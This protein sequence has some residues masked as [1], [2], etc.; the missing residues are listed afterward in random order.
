M[1]RYVHKMQNILFVSGDFTVTDTPNWIHVNSVS[2][3]TKESR[4]ISSLPLELNWHT[5]R[6]SVV[7]IVTCTPLTTGRT[8]KKEV[9]VLV[10]Q[11]AAASLSR[12]TFTLSHW[13]SS[14]RSVHR[15]LV[16]TQQ[17]GGGTC[18]SGVSFLWY[19]F[20]TWA[21]SFVFPVLFCSLFHSLY[22]CLTSIPLSSAPALISLMCLINLP[23]VF[24]WMCLTLPICFVCCPCSFGSCA[25]FCF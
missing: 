18:H 5:V 6:N 20:C 25:W 9:T 11:D 10:H 2:V 21:S 1:Y 4:R 23:C 8:E 13:L 15:T 12:D 17:V 22:I 3:V 14:D 7:T 19:G 16:L 24:R